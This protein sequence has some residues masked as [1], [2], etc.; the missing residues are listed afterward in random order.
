MANG[1]AFGEEKVAE[2]TETTEAT[3]GARRI[4][5]PSA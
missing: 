3:S 4:S 2:P 1:P 5:L